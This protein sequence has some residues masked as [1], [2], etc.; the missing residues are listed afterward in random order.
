MHGEEFM[1]FPFKIIESRISRRNEF[2]MKDGFQPTH[3]L[4]YLKKGRFEI[5]I[6]GIT[7]WRYLPENPKEATNE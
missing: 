7:H 4:F 6:D 5:E 3:A 2:D 1:Q